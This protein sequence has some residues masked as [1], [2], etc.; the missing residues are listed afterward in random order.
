M[1]KQISPEKALV[2]LEE[3]CARAER[4]TWELR[5][6][7]AAWK[8]SADDATRIIESLVERRFVDDSRFAAAFVRDK[9]RFERWGR[10]KIAMELRIKHIPSDV[11][12]EAL[13]QIDEDTYL[14]NLHA[15]A[16]ARYK[17]KEGEDPRLMHQ[18]LFRALVSRGYEPDLAVEAI[19][20]AAF[21]SL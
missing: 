19:K 14:S 7:L 15:I 3:M 10:R 20:A 18:R 21:N 5:R 9:Y 13:E 12:A 16:K 6:K 17:L 2:K 1:I 4:C 11:I 8:I